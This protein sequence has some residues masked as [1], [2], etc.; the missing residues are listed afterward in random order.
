MCLNS[1]NNVKILVYEKDAHMRERAVQLIEKNFAEALV[2][3]FYQLQDVI[4]EIRISK[5]N[6]LI[7]V[8]LLSPHLEQS[9]HTPEIS[10]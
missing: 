9:L 2:L 8:Q 10:C 6:K 5:S 3:E 1:S 7:L 4:E